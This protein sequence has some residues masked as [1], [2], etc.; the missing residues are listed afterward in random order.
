MILPDVFGISTHMK[1]LADKYAK[2]WHVSNDST[3]LNLISKEAGVT[4]FIPDIFG[5]EPAP[6]KFLDKPNSTP[7]DFILDFLGRNRK[8]KR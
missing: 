5:G 8:E 7:N 6:I 1:L 3:K 4:V 2:V